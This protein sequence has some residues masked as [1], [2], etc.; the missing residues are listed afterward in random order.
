MSRNKYLSDVFKDSRRAL[1]QIIVYLYSNMIVRIDYSTVLL[2]PELIIYTSRK[3][4]RRLA[5]LDKKGIYL[6]NRLHKGISVADDVGFVTFACQISVADGVGF[7]ISV[8]VRSV[9][10]C[11]KIY[12]IPCLSNGPL[13]TPLKK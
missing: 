8:I 10:H 13:T 2:K 5:D 3:L 11:E 1:I 9:P 6:P 12:H 4:D 7:A